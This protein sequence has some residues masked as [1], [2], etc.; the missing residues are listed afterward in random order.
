MFDEHIN[1]EITEIAI[2]V[3]F[4]ENEV[5]SMVKMKKDLRL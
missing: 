2:L 1:G 3:S 5:S 4:L